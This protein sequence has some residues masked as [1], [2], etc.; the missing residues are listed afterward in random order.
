MSGLIT[1]MLGFAGLSSPPPA[2]RRTAAAQPR[3]RPAPSRP[4]AVGS[5]PSKAVVDSAFAGLSDDMPAPR[6]KKGGARRPSAAPARKGRRISTFGMLML[7]TACVTAGTWMGGQVQAFTMG[8][9]QS[10]H[11]PKADPYALIGGSADSVRVSF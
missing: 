3:R 10:S 1:A 2:K 8:A 4:K 11:A 6:S 7:A 9:A 5:K